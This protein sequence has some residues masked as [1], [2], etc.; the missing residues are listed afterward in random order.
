[1][2]VVILLC[3]DR[4]IGTM[5]ENKKKVVGEFLGSAFISFWG[6]GLAV[7]FRVLGYVN[8]TYEVA[9]WFGIACA[10]AGIIFSTISGG[11]CNS[12]VTLAWAIFG[13]FD[14][15]L[16]LPYWIAQILG[17]GTGILP[18]YI[19]FDNVLEEWASTTTKNPGSL[20]YC[21]TPA[22]ELLA[23]AG[24]EIF[25]TAMLI[26]CVFVFLDDRITS[27]PSAVAYP[28]V[29]GII[30]SLNIAFGGGFTGTCINTTRDLGPRIAG[31]IYG[32]VKGYDI[33]CIFADGQWLM[34]I[35]APMIGAVLGGAFYYGVIAKLL[36]ERDTSELLNEEKQNSKGRLS[37]KKRF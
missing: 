34:Y 28:W 30:I 9:I 3:I 36:P 4:G 11:H 7:P 20:F 10:L 19:I 5:S 23:G 31:W 21:T 29:V 27:R 24:L 17:W 6:L 16:I 22:D 35:I 37:E 12:S 15:K 14:K 2:C 32:L 13:G 33:S 18:I 8:S 26:F 1:M 25:L